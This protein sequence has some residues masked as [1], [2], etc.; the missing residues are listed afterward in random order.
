MIKGCSPT[1]AKQSFCRGVMR[2]ALDSLKI[3]YF[4]ILPY[5]VKKSSNIQE[6]ASTQ[7][8]N[9]EDCDEFIYAMIKGSHGTETET[10]NQEFKTER[11]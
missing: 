3:A 6:A 4:K 1:E 9:N 2:E 8:D 5:Q 10:E 7:N 11:Q